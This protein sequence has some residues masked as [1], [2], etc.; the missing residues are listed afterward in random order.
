MKLPQIY[1]GEWIQPVHRGFK[2]ACCGCGLVH[3]VDFKVVNGAVWFRE[4]IDARST[5]AVRREARKAK[6]NKA[7]GPKGAP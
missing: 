6:N 7:H 5:A 1:E 3:R 2:A 4:S